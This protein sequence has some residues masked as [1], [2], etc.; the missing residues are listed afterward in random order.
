MLSPIP[1]PDP[2]PPVRSGNALTDLCVA[3]SE[4]EARDA[5][6]RATADEFPR[7]WRVVMETWPTAVDALY[8]HPSADPSS[9]EG[10]A[11]RLHGAVWEAILT[12]ARR[13][14]A[15]RLADLLTSCSRAPRR[16]RFT[17]PA[18][19]V[20]DA[21][22]IFTDPV[23]HAHAALGLIQLSELEAFAAPDLMKRLSESSECVDGDR[24]HAG[25]AQYLAN[26]SAWKSGRPE[27]NV[28]AIPGV[29]ANESLR[30][31]I[32]ATGRMGVIV[33]ALRASSG[34]IPSLILDDASRTQPAT[35]IEI[36]EAYPAFLS[37][38]DRDVFARLLLAEEPQLRQ[39]ALFLLPRWEQARTVPQSQATAPSPP[40]RSTR[41]PAR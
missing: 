35:T 8:A 9:D 16:P 36:L 31:T 30:R 17:K 21:V 20:L 32:V 41:A 19:G 34:D 3:A 25:L 7:L 26:H 12:A 10:V 37:F 27:V 5:I 22:G 28:A 39:R 2:A 1:H 4:S 23:L 24:L 29:M 6:S 14:H 15:E 13:A 18:E 40:R 33:R 11:T 38:A